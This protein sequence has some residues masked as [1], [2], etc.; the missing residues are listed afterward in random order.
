VSSLD[1]AIY[2][3]A[4]AGWLCSE[5]TSTEG[6]LCVCVYTV[7]QAGVE[8]A[9]AACDPSLPCCNTLEIAGGRSC[10]C[11]DRTGEDCDEQV[12]RGAEYSERVSSCPGE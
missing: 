6:T 12:N 1:A 2:A 7:I 5:T 11:S 4:S 8:D 3:D 10:T 9:S